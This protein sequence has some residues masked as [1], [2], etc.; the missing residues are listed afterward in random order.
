[1]G[2]R[3]RH[4]R[5]LQMLDRL[6]QVSQ[7]LLLRLETL[8]RGAGVGLSIPMVLRFALPALPLKLLR[9]LREL[10]F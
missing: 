9:R 8:L 5:R 7:T 10:L 1:M 6:C 4:A 2:G 3:F